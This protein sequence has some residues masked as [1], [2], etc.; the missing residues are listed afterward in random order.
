[1]A[2]EVGN[3]LAAVGRVHDLGVKLNAV[4]AALVVGRRSE[5]GTGRLSDDPEAF[6]KNVDLVAVAHP[7]LVALARRPQAVEQAALVRHLE[8]G[9]AELAMIARHYLAAELLGHKLLPVANAE[10]GQLRLEQRVRR[11]GAVFEGDGGRPPE[12]ITPLGRIRSSAS[13]ARLNG[14]ISL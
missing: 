6:G 13:S 11:A 3:Q 10:H 9:A 7:D 8:E 12:R 4:E 2:H 5:G 1:M 14:T